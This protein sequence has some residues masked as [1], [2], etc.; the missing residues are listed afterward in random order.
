MYAKEDSPTA[1]AAAFTNNNDGSSC[2]KEELVVTQMKN[3]T[4]SSQVAETKRNDVKI[5]DELRREKDELRREIE[6]LEKKSQKDLE[7][8]NQQLKVLRKKN[9][10]L[11]T[12][13]EELEKEN[14]ILDIKLRASKRDYERYQR[15]HKETVD[16]FR[17]LKP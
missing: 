17:S 8:N 6:Y 3:L 12:E 1:E 2:E 7:K 9:R 16:T 5:I 15:F 14:K 11:E 4:V 13:K 10:Q